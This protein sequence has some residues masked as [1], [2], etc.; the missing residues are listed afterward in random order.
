MR[1]ADHQ[2]AAMFS[3]FIPTDRCIDSNVIS[4]GSSR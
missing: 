4:P 1:G 2:T 3:Y